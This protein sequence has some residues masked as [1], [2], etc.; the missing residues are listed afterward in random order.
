MN[1]QKTDF[2][3]MDLA[4]VSAE[5]AF[6]VNEVPIGA[7]LV[8]PDG[9]V[10]ATAHNLV[11]T[12]KRQTAHA[13]LLVIDQATQILNDWR[14]EGCTLFVTLE[15]CSMCFSAATLSRVQKIVFG[16]H[17]ALFGFQSNQDVFIKP[18][19]DEKVQVEGGIREKESLA[20]LKR[21]FEGKRG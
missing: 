2:E 19:G 4:L 18:I 12:Y 7:L 5:K 15:P 17:S 9:T 13:E 8:A 20:L 3:Y 14:L 11:E 1:I 6:S 16:A 21:F 10:L